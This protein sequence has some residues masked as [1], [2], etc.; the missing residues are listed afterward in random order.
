MRFPEGG[1]MGQNLAGSQFA[2]LCAAWAMSASD[3]LTVLTTAGHQFS[4]SLIFREF[5]KPLRFSDDDG[6]LTQS[7]IARFKAS[8]SDEMKIACIAYAMMHF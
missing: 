8:H 3:N 7:N 2:K 4:S 1:R 5:I 6:G